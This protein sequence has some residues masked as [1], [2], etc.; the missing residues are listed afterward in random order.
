MLLCNLSLIH[1]TPSQLS[2][3]WL[4][5]VFQIFCWLSQGDVMLILVFV[6]W[7]IITWDW[8]TLLP[9]DQASTDLSWLIYHE[10]YFQILNILITSPSSVKYFYSSHFQIIF[11]A[12]Y[13]C[14]PLWEQELRLADVAGGSHLT[15][16]TL[17]SVARGSL[18]A[19]D[20]YSLQYNY[21]P[22]KTEQSTAEKVIKENFCWSVDLN[23]IS[24]RLFN[25][26]WP[27]SMESENQ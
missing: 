27:F 8:I 6:M 21:K 9:R 3:H 10:Y 15:C 5:T 16:S 23:I 11:G 17:C 22:I 1:Q 12:S 26:I 24:K 25:K 4:L 7:L 2:W 14:F 13:F 20:I 19:A 18:H